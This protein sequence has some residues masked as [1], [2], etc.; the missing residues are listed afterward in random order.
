MA[1]FSIRENV[2]QARVVVSDQHRGMSLAVVSD[3]RV[4]G[5]RADQSTWP[6]LETGE[7]G[8]LKVARGPHNVIRRTLEFACE[9]PEVSVFLGTPTEVLATLHAQARSTLASADLLFCDDVEKLPVWQRPAVAGDAAEL[10]RIASAIGL[11]VSERTAHRV[12]GGEI[13]P[14]QPVLAIA[15]GSAETADAS[16]DEPP[17]DIYRDRRGLKVHHTDLA[18]FRRELERAFDVIAER[19]YVHLR[20]EP[21]I[22]VGRDEIRVRFA[23]EKED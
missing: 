12:L 13:P 11:A 17:A 23:V 2:S 3:C 7:D 1:L 20:Q 19:Y 21:K 16:R 22:V 9:H 18:E 10:V 5:E 6:V 8:A 4:L 14:L 15:G